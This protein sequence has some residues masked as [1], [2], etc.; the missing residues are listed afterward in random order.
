[1]VGGRSPTVVAK[2][3]EVTDKEIEADYAMKAAAITRKGKKIP[4]GLVARAQLKEMSRATLLREKM[5][6]AV[7]EYIAE[8]RKKAKIT[9][10]DAILPKV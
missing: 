9:V 10:N 2:R 5:K 3:V 7:D 6:T 8:L 1:M 4:L